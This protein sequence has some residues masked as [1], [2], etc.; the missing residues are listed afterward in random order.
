[1]LQLDIQDVRLEDVV[2]RIW[3]RL[4]PELSAIARHLFQ[5]EVLV[6]ECTSEADLLGLRQDVAELRKSLMNLTILTDSTDEKQIVPTHVGV[7]ISS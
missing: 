4:G 6:A 1:M 3:R 2:G 7:R 5:L